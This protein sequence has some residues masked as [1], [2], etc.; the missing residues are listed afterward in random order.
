MKGSLS[1]PSAFDCSGNNQS[2]DLATA[3]IK[4]GGKGGLSGRV[5][6]IV[7]ACS[8]KVGLLT[9][10]P[11]STNL[12]FSF[13][14]STQQVLL[15]GSASMIFNNPMG[16]PIN[17]SASI[18]YDLLKNKIISLTGNI[19]SPFVL[20]IPPTSPVLSF[21]IDKAQINEKTI[22]IDGRQA[23]R[24]GNGTTLGVTFSNLAVNWHDFSIAGGKVIF[25]TPFALKA[26]IA[27]S[28]LQFAAVPRGTALTEPVGIMLNLPDSIEIGPGGFA[29]H[30]AE[31]SR[32]LV[33][34]GK[35][36][37]ERWC[38]KRWNSQGDYHGGDQSE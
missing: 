32:R 27:G 25:D 31:G 1:L 10:V 7:P 38:A 22:T 6:N 13:A 9:L 35:D 18:S 33:Q 11:T 16:T 21:N 28:D 5:E 2:V 17:A 34:G 15:D 24:F 23:L 8:L 12:T 19:N 20:N 14:D 36:A 26:A 29:A 37:I 30:G 3:I 4:L